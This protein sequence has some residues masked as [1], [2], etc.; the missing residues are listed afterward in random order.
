MDKTA[1]YI[2]LQCINTFR[3][4]S[5]GVEDTPW[6]IRPCLGG[7]CFDFPWGVSPST[8][9]RKARHYDSILWWHSLNR[10]GLEGTLKSSVLAPPSALWCYAQNTSDLPRSTDRVGQGKQQRFWRHV[11][12][13]S[14]F[15]LLLAVGPWVLIL[16][17]LSFLMYKVVI[18]RT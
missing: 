9:Q 4:K 5:S 2:S 17:W 15:C 11:A 6:P 8:S 7:A 1:V 18:I 10:R 3:I 13:Q 12:C 14:W 16:L